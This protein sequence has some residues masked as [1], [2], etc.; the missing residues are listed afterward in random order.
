MHL[1]SEWTLNNIVIK[2]KNFTSLL[3]VI[4]LLLMKKINTQNRQIL[5]AANV[6]PTIIHCIVKANG[7]I[8]KW[9]F[10]YKILKDIS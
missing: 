5:Y 2:K 3:I 7:L 1:F 4:I 10:V 8:L 6:C 9:F